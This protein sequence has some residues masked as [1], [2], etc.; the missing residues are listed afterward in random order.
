MYRDGL[1]SSGMMPGGAARRCLAVGGAA[2]TLQTR[3]A[4]PRYVRYT[5][6][7]PMT[8]LNCRRTMTSETEWRTGERKMNPLRRRVTVGL[9]GRDR[10]GCGLWWRFE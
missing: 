5:N 4:R 1:P 8:L 3:S 6:L 7:C 9:F 2:V 10:G